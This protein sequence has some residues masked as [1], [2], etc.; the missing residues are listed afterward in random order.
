MF[1]SI[2]V[3]S[4]T[5]S[6]I[7]R[8]WNVSK[9]TPL[10]NISVKKTGFHVLQVVCDSQM[11]RSAAQYSESDTVND[12][13]STSLAQAPSMV[14]QAQFAL[15][16]ARIVCAFHDGGIGLYDLGRRKWDFLR[17]QVTFDHLLT[18]V[19]SRACP[20][21]ISAYFLQMVHRKSD[22]GADPAHKF[23]GKNFLSS[24]FI[25]HKNVGIHLPSTA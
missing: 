19:H 8:V 2:S 11:Q 18:R 12:V 7:L 15:P 21:A 14:N 10:E 17:D 25:P 23:S 1:N 5:L 20:C 9:P 22:E 3:I 16:Q 6:G 4:D 13:S 24:E